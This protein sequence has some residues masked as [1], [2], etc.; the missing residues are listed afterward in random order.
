MV[1]L[2]LSC[3]QGRPMRWAFDELRAL[4]VGIQLTPGNEPSRGFQAHVAQSQTCVRTHHGFSFSA[5]QTRVWA[6]AGELLARSDSVHPPKLG[7]PAAPR[8]DEWLEQSS[9]TVSLET[10]YPGYRLG[11][12]AELERAMAL[13]RP[14]AVD[15]SHLFIQRTAGVMG[16]ATLRRL[17]DYPHVTEVHVSQNDGRNDLHRL[18]RAD[19]FGLAWALEKARAGVPLIHEAYLH[20]ASEDVRRAQ[21]ELLRG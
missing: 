9:A 16:E 20:R 10:M 14:L 2:A 1:F 13:E 12:G 6:D 8:F 7:S 18:L 11:T 3:L 5:R 15:V 21:L 4:G 17:F 19:A